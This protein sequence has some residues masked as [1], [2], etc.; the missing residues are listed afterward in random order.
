MALPPLAKLIANAT[1]E[2]GL[3]IVNLDEDRLR[4]WNVTPTALRLLLEEAGMGIA[5]EVPDRTFYVVAKQNPLKILEEQWP[6]LKK[7]LAPRSLTEEE[8]QYITDM[9]PNPYGVDELSILTSADGIRTTIGSLLQSVKLSPLMIEPFI[10][11]LLEKFERSRIAPGSTVGLTA[12]EA[13]A[14]PITQMALNSFHVSGT[15]KHVGSGVNAIRELLNVSPIRTAESMTIYFKEEYQGQWASKEAFDGLLQKRREL[16]N[17]KLSYFISNDFFF[18]SDDDEGDESRRKIIN[19]YLTIKGREIIPEDFE[20]L[21]LP[22]NSVQMYSY[23]I[24]AY[25]MVPLFEELGSGDECYAVPTTLRKGELY[26]VARRGAMLSTPN[27][28]TQKQTLQWF[29]QFSVVGKL[30]SMSLGGIRGITS[31]FINKVP[32]M[33]YIRSFNKVGQN[34]YRGNINQIVAATSG[35]QP[36]HIENLCDEAGIRIV[37]QTDDYILFE[38]PEEPTRIIGQGIEAETLHRAFLWYIETNGSNL[39]KVLCRRDVDQRYT[40]CNNTVQIFEVYGIEAVRNFLFRDMYSTLGIDENYINP[41]NLLLLVDH[42]TAKG[43]PF[44]ITYS[45]MQ[46]QLQGQNAFAA[47]TSEKPI[48]IFGQAAQFGSSQNPNPTSVGILL[49]KRGEYGTGSFKLGV[50]KERA[51]QISDDDLLSALQNISEQATEGKLAPENPQEEEE[52][53]TVL[54][55][56]RDLLRPPPAARGGEIS[57]KTTPVK[58]LE[59]IDDPRYPAE[60]STSST[61]IVAN[62]AVEAGTAIAEEAGLSVAPVKRVANITAFRRRR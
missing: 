17:L 28:L 26:I 41:R 46:Q 7:K 56:P 60:A 61:P 12:A 35:I 25:D 22:L 3:W 10:E 48:E 1:E 52:Q 31:C 2:G 32:V 62:L 4:Q 47:A 9:L 42:I 20:F 54:F 16:T 38:S 30:D 18:S 8:I 11:E 45:G 36:Y 21:I 43:R 15:A 29:Y 34:Q 53:G 33:S 49:G 37:E 50:I 23:R 44:G 55:D 24:T 59:E 5:R 6:T 51:E 13:V 27:G 57:P 58:I 40:T 19:D 39:R 14:G